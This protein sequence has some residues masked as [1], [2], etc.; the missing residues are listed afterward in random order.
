MNQLV[1][2]TIVFEKY[3]EVATNDGLPFPSYKPLRLQGAVMGS[4][5]GLDVS[6]QLPIEIFMVRK[7]TTDETAIEHIYGYQIIDI[8]A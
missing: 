7:N 5:I 6:R 8:E 3:L 2:K 1:G 4:Y